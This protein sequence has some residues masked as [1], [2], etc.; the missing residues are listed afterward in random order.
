MSWGFRVV[1]EGEALTPLCSCYCC[2][3][4]WGTLRNRWRRPSHSGREEGRLHVFF[5]TTERHV[6]DAEKTIYMSLNIPN[7]NQ[8]QANVLTLLVTTGITERF[9]LAIVHQR[10]GQRKQFTSNTKIAQNQNSWSNK[11]NLRKT[12]S[13][14]EKWMS[15]CESKSSP[16]MQRLASITLRPTRSPAMT[17][18]SSSIIKAFAS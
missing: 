13:R 9:I 15:T 5:F 14:D 2:R 17:A 11:P 8:V 6:W 10:N 3:C 16:F 7:V 4:L 12:K 18:P 1:R